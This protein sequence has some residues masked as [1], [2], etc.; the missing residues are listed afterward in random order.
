M[1]LARAPRIELGPLVWKT[2]MLPL[3]TMHALE[4][5]M[6][7]EPIFSRWQREVL[8]LDELCSGGTDRTL[9]CVNPGCNRTPILSA[10]VPIE[11]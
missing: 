3:N 11:G 6:G 10:T 2:S 7:V 8:P 9:T 1:K 5:S 4:P